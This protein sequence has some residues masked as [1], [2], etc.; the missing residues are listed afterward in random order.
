MAPPAHG[1]KAR[2]QPENWERRAD[3]EEWPKAR[4][5]FRL[6]DR[7]EGRIRARDGPCDKGVVSNPLSRSKGAAPMRP[8]VDGLGTSAPAGTGGKN[9]DAGPAER[10]CPKLEDEGGPLLSCPV[11]ASRAG[12]APGLD[13]AM[14]AQAAHGRRRQSH[15]ASKRMAHRP[16]PARRAAA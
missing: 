6:K 10:R 12:Q 3:R 5:I 1:H 16:R 8:A 15:G 13:R 14:A 7:P 11:R 2:D 4:G 9:G